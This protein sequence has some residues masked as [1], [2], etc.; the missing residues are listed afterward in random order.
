MFIKITEIIKRG[1]FFFIIWLLFFT[2]ILNGFHGILNDFI[3]ISHLNVLFVFCLIYWFACSAAWLLFWIWTT[4]WN[5]LIIFSNL[6]HLHFFLSFF[7][8]QRFGFAI[9]LVVDLRI[10]FIFLRLILSIWRI[11]FFVRSCWSKSVSEYVL[12]LILGLQILLIR[13]IKVY[14]HAFLIIAFEWGMSWTHESTAFISRLS[15]IIIL[16]IFRFWTLKFF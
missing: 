11:L 5:D 13:W 2:E 1:L 16:L 7:I 9:E 15:H 10:Y 3:N 12:I 4:I 6:T 14:L 8:N